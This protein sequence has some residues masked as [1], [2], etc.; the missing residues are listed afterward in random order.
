MARTPS[1][2]T[3]VVTEAEGSGPLALVGDA[4]FFEKPVDNM[5]NAEICRMSLED[6]S[7][8]NLGAGRQRSPDPVH[9]GAGPVRRGFP[10]IRQYCADGIPGR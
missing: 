1:G 7:I 6:L 2:E 4:L 10:G 9:H 5:G 3:S 8:Q